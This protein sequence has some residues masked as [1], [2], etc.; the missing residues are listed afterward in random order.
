MTT[1]AEPLLQWPDPILEF[2]GFI[3]LFL[4][5][6]AVGFHLL[7]LTSLRRSTLADE[8]EFAGISSRRAARLALAGAALSLALFALRVP[9]MA[10][11]RHLGLAALFA[12]DPML[13]VQ[14]GLRVLALVGFGL[15]VFRVAWGWPLAALGVVVGLL[16]SAL[17]G[18]WARLINPMHALAGGLWIGTLFFVLA[19]G[20]PAAMSAARPA[21]RREAITARLIHAFSPLALVSA[22]TLALFGAITAWRHLKHLSALWVTPYGITLLV[23]LGVVATVLALGAW[24]WRRVKPRLGS[25]GGALTLRRNARAEILAAGLVLMITAVLVSLPSP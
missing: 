8:R 25:E 6:G 13:Q 20:L 19:A 3:A 4:T 5:T 12:G 22:A 1:G 2:A 18:Q 14:G 7:V 10:A 21:D 17:F 11:E 23:K 24:N 16:R 15:A 9:Q